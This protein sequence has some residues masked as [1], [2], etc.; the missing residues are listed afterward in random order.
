MARPAAPHPIER[1]RL[2]PTPRGRPK[3]G[4]GF[5]RHLADG[6]RPS[7]GQQNALQI[8]R[9]LFGAGRVPEAPPGVPGP[10]VQHAPSES[11]EGAR[12]PEFAGGSWEK[13]SRRN[14]HHHLRLGAGGRQFV[15]GVAPGVR[16]VVARRGSSSCRTRGASRSPGRNDLADGRLPGRDVATPKF[17]GPCRLRSHA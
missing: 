10:F 12:A 14:H 15:R 3:T 7:G 17:P 9:A 1:C 16:P 6:G 8:L 4:G 13:H 5:G 2:R 11:R